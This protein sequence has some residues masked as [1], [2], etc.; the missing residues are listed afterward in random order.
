MAK[1]TGEAAKAWKAF[2]RLKRVIDC[3][4]YSG[5]PFVGQCITCRR[6]YHITYLEAGHCLTGRSNGVLFSRELVNA[7]CNYCN[8][9]MHGCIKKYKKLMKAKYGEEQFEQWEIK[10]RN[11][12]HDR[13]MDFE[14]R[15]Q[16]YRDELMAILAP[17]GY[18]SWDNLLGDGK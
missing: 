9:I 2:S 11:P 18:D 15:T 3:M 17:L 6:Q 7:Q 10:A 12:I 5:L 1:Q 13:D 8:M 16:R 4:E 14:G